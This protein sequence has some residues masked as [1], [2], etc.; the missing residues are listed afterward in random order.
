MGD[1]MNFTDIDRV[2]QITLKNIDTLNFAEYNPRQLTTD[3]YNQLK[4]S[5]TKYGLVD[6]I[7]INRKT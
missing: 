4:T 3:Q 1:N 5:I 6:T 7:I 2:E